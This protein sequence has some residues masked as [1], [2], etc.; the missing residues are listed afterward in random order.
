MASFMIF[1]N[2]EMGIIFLQKAVANLSLK[3]NNDMFYI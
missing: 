1:Q 2:A 3:S